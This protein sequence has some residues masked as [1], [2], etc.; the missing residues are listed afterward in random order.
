MTVA[1]HSTPFPGN[2]PGGRS[3]AETGRSSDGEGAHKPAKLV[4]RGEK[5]LQ[6]R[7]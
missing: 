5:Y 4:L 3:C 2:L 6:R 1:G 7:R